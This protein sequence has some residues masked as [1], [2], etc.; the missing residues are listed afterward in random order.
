MTTTPTGTQA[1]PTNN[2]PAVTG[3]K[4][5]AGLKGKQKR[6]ITILKD[7]FNFDIIERIVKHVQQ[8]E[9]AKKIKPLEKARLLQN[10]YLT[11]LS[12]CIPKMKI[13]EDTGDKKGS[14]QFNINVGGTP[15]DPNNQQVTGGVNIVIPTQKG[16]DGSY[17]VDPTLPQLPSSNKKEG[18]Q[19]PNS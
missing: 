4:A 11:L 17:T 9:R 13:Q 3:S 8:L 2:P 15:L 16:A 1:Q 7:D 14:V 6:F 18:S 12:F 5:V 19:N 10:Y